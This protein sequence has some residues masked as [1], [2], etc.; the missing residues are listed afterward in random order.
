MFVGEEQRVEIVVHH[1]EGVEVCARKEGECRGENV[2]AQ[3]AI[4][5][6]CVWIQLVREIDTE[7]C[8]TSKQK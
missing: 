2:S 7:L 5:P 8:T 3:V 1:R 6:N 4:H